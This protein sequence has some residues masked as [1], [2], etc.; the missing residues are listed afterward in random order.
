MEVSI[1]V[2]RF[3]IYKKPELVNTKIQKVV[4]SGENFGNFYFVIFAY[5]LRKFSN[6]HVLLI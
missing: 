4:S 2:D 1:V 3:H 6:E 5:L